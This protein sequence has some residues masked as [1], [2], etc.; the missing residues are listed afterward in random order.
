MERDTNGKKYTLKDEIKKRSVL[1][2]TEKKR[3]KNIQKLNMKEHTK[4][5]QKEKTRTNLSKRTKGRHFK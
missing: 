3:I 4:I 1:F 5:Y 2:A